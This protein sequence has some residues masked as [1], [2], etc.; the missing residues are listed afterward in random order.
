M[1][2]WGEDAYL[3]KVG[4]ATTA[5]QNLCLPSSQRS[6]HWM[7]AISGTIWK[8]RSLSLLY[9]QA[10][11]LCDIVNVNKSE[12]PVPS[13]ALLFVYLDAV[14]R[15]T[16][17]STGSNCGVKT[18]SPATVISIFTSSTPSSASIMTRPLGQA[19]GA[20]KLK[21]VTELIDKLHEDIKNIAL[22]PSGVYPNQP[23]MCHLLIPIQHRPRS[24][25]GGT[26]DLQ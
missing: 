4:M 14:S 19:T 17:S 2:A 12:L 22:L 23:T 6:W 26:Q 5:R 11:C 9:L 3:P 1:T 13:S 8:A 15:R 25:L 24:R 20:E 16:P 21:I 10:P 7:K 18:E